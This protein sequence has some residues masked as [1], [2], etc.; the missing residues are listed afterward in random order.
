MEKLV[1]CAQPGRS[2]AGPPARR[3]ATVVDGG[4][5]VTLRRVGEDLAGRGVRRLMVEGGGPVHTQLLSDDL[6]DELQLVVAPSSSATPGP[7]GSSA[8][9]ASP[10]RPGHRATLAE[11]RQIGDVVLLRYALS[12]RFGR[13]RARR[14]HERRDA[15]IR[16]QVSSRSPSP[17]ASARPPGASPSTGLDDGR[18]HL[19]LGLGDWADRPAGRHV[20][21][22]P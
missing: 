10:G 22:P 6:A 12:P 13:E 19:A 11:V 8:T 7:A 3:L 17:T 18:E 14:T 21:R 4:D 1:Y 9:P 2:S 5:P 16:A 15:T 20:R